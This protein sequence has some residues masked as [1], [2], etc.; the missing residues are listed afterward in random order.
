MKRVIGI[1]FL[2]VTFYIFV[3]GDWVVSHVSTNTVNRDFFLK[4]SGAFFVFWCA[5]WQLCDAQ[6]CAVVLLLFLTAPC[7][8]KQHTSQ[9]P[10]HFPRRTIGVGG[11]F[12]H[13]RMEVI[14]FFSQNRV[15]PCFPQSFPIC[16]KVPLSLVP[17]NQSPQ[18]SAWVRSWLGTVG[19]WKAM[20]L[21]STAGGEA[22]DGSA[23][24]QIAGILQCFL[25]FQIKNPAGL[26]VV[27]LSIYLPTYL[28]IYLSIDRSIYLSH[29]IWS[30]LIRSDPIR[31]DPIRSDPIRS[32]PIRSDPILSIYLSIYLYSIRKVWYWWR[33]FTYVKILN[34][35]NWVTFLGGG[36]KSEHK[37]WGFITRLVGFW[38]G[39]GRTPEWI[40]DLSY[41]FGS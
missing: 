8:K 15:F 36:M 40:L 28:S 23:V 12:R 16:R 6:C 32:D 19:G 2:E 35:F 20:D 13:F 25:G 29:L 21:W 18:R 5:N 14:F 1:L 3:I 38:L 34:I 31:S 30:D 39:R 4:S 27:Y 10:I 9:L 7:P 33:W 37:T 41:L 22:L 24:P 26:N 17:G 11:V